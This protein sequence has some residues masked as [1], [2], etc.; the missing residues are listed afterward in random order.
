MDLE[1]TALRI[2]EA[3]FA[4]EESVEVDGEVYDIDL[5]S[6]AKVK[7]VQIDD[8]A[9]LEQNPKKDS[10]WAEE[11]REG[12]QIM[13][14]LRGRKYLARVRNGRFLDLRKE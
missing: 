8:L 2:Y 3:M 1:E 11:A 6:R 9:F 10:H 14:V 7:R 12:H 5:T 4:D 13:W